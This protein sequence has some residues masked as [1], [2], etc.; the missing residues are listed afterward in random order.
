MYRRNAFGRTRPHHRWPE[1]RSDVIGFA[2]SIVREAS[3]HRM[4]THRGSNN[5]KT[6]VD[7]L[8]CLSLSG[9]SRPGPQK[10]V[11][12][13][14]LQSNPAPN[15]LFAT[16]GPENTMALLMRRLPTSPRSSS[17]VAM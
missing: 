3:R 17:S 11:T 1:R 4:L 8:A 10:G 7:V 12:T 16:S 5:T 9:I 6:N 13:P 15:T 14:A 2:L